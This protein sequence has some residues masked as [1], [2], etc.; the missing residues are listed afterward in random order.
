[1]ELNFDKEMDALLRQ[2][3]RSGEFVSTNSQTH[4][5]ADEISAFAEN[6]LPEK[7]RGVYIKHFADCDRCRAILSNTILLNSEAEIETASSVVTANA[8]E[9]VE[10]DIPWYRNFFAVRNLAYTMG[11]LVILFGG[12]I[13]FLVY[14]STNNFQ[15]AELS[16]VSDNEPAAG[17]PNLESGAVAANSNAANVTNMANTS[18]NTA[19]AN[20]SV[21]TFNSSAA[22]VNAAVSTANTMMSSAPTPDILAKETRVGRN[23]LTEQPLESKSRAENSKSE[24]E[25][26]SDKK[27]VALQSADSAMSTGT[28][29]KPVAAAPP[30]KKM[31][32]QDARKAKRSV[33]ANDVKSDDESAPT[34][35]ISGKT[36]NR[37][38]DVW[39]DANYRGQSTTNVRRN[40]ENY[41]KLDS[42]LRTIAESLNGTVVVVWKDKAYR[43]Q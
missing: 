34:R 42:G 36:F 18:A 22:N 31:T 17:S 8:P 5:D 16:K 38:D 6:A 20:T 40:T 14:Q 12:F 26:V 41:R 3:A 32:D 37:K 4:L 43:I 29:P 2:A 7:T 23:Q 30:A 13:G 25:T 35:Q 24:E 19:A 11:A 21:Y 1:M 15:N 39:Y 28:S 9:I 10:A 33:S 27:E